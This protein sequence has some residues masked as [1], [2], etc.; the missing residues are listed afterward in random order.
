MSVSIL[1]LFLIGL[2]MM[3]YYLGIRRSLAVAGTAGRRALNSLPGHYGMLAA[4]WCIVPALLVVLLWV[5]FQETI[6]TQLVVAALPPE[7]PVLSEAELTLV[8]NDIKNL[9][10]GN[11]VSGEQTPVMR[12]AAEHYLQLEFLSRLALSVI[13]TVLAALGTAVVWRRINP[14]MRARNHVENIVRIF[15]V[16]SSTLAIVTTVGIVLSVLFES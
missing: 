1:L 3:A 11:I 5:V 14:Q 6:I 13:V 4:L 9:A 16:L 12:A 2:T 10:S 7:Q 8:V 15:L